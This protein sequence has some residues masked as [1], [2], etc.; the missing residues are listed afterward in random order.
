VEKMSVLLVVFSVIIQVVIALLLDYSSQFRLNWDSIL[1]IFLV[2]L[3]NLFRLI[4]WGFINKRYD[5]SKTYPVTTL[6]FPIIYVISLWKGETQL[7]GNKLV[8]MGLIIIGIIVIQAYNKNNN[9]ELA[10]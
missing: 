7:L 6:F 5:L 10:Q 4:I 9:G 3:L 8:G 2:L 1:I